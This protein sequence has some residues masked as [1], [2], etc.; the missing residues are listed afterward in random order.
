M[1]ANA[2]EDPQQLPKLFHTFLLDQGEG[3]FQ[4]LSWTQTIVNTQP[5]EIEVSPDQ[6]DLL[7][8]LSVTPF[9]CLGQGHIKVGQILKKSVDVHINAMLQVE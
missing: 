8:S 1:C 5:V 9:L 7:H 2:S 3:G 4:E 6:S